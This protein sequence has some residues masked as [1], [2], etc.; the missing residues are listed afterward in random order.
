MS[1]SRCWWYKVTI[2]EARC[3]A[4]VLFTGQPCLAMSGQD[5]SEDYWNGNLLSLL[6]SHPRQQLSMSSS[7]ESTEAI[8][9]KKF[10]C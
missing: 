9:C 1:M 7:S 5:A 4:V 2:M 3:R 6:I 8:V 10:W